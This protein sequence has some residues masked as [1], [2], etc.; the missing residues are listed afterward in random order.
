MLLSQYSDK[1]IVKA[2]IALSTLSLVCP[3]AIAA[4]FIA[5]VVKAR[6]EK[7]EANTKEKAELSR[8]GTKN[9][10]SK[11]IGFVYNGEAR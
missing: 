7:R 2:G 6:R 1:N 11:T 10:G 3:S 4:V 5:T 8:C 9:D